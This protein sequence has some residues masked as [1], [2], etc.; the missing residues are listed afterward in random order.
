MRGPRPGPAQ[1]RGGAAHRLRM[2]APVLA[3]IGQNPGRRYRPRLRP[4][5]RDPR[6]GRHHRAAGRLVGAHPQA[7]TGA[8]PGRRKAHA[9]DAQRPARP[10]GARMRHRRVGQVRSGDVW[11]RRCRVPA[12]QIDDDAV[13]RAA[14]RLGAAKRPLIICGGGAQD[15][16]AEVTALS[17]TCCRRR[18]SAI[19]AAAAC[20]TAAIRLASTLPLGHELWA[21]ADVVLGGRHA[22]AHASCAMGH[23]PRSRDHPHRRRSGGADPHRTSRRWR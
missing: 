21:E 10:G 18:C 19:G 7:A 3:L 1:F 14:K 12:P 20:S 4:S 17:R 22:A 8:A 5:A 15:A 6:P 23:R 2:N 11:Q 13:R 16:S 9:C